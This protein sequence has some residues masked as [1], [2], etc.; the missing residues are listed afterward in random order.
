VDV[1][2]Q[3]VAPEP[4]RH[5]LGLAQDRREQRRDAAQAEEER[6]VAAPP[7]EQRAE[8]LRAGRRLAGGDRR[9]HERG[10][11][12]QGLGV[13]QPAE[14]HGADQAAAQLR[15]VPLQAQRQEFVCERTSERLHQ[16]PAHENREPHEH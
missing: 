1:L 14:L 12:P 10:R 4:E 11:E 3:D 13:G 6:A 16:A 7:V 2:Q 5:G 15:R 8:R 9:R